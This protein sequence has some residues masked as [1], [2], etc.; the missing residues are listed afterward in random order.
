MKLGYVPNELLSGN[1]ASIEKWRK[2]QMLGIT[3]LRRKDLLEKAE[4]SREEKALL[5]EFFDELE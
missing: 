5:E 4:L 3:A 2:K 1:H